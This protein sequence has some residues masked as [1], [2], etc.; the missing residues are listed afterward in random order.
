MPGNP[1]GSD[2]PVW[3]LW[4]FLA[5][6]EG[7]GTAHRRADKPRRWRSTRM[8]GRTEDRT[9]GRKRR[10]KKGRR[11][12]TGDAWRRGK[13]RSRHARRR[14]R[15][16]DTTPLTKS[17]K[18]RRRAPARDA[19]RTSIRN[20]EDT[21]WWVSRVLPPGVVVLILQNWWHVLCNETKSVTLSHSTPPNDSILLIT[22]DIQRIQTACKIPTVKGHLSFAFFLHQ[23]DEVSFCIKLDKS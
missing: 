18:E 19:D 17:G 15:H 8:R 14:D 4:L 9:K 22:D 13:R 5:A 2:G 20:R 23:R 3:Q 12:K 7:G 1:R 10:R 16:A 11:R 21:A 6:R